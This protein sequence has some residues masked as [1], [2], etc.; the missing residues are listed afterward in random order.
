MIRT[1]HSGEET[2][3]NHR[4]FRRVIFRE[5]YQLVTDRGESLGASVAFDLSVGGIR[6]RTEDFLPVNSR[7]SI[8][9]SCSDNRVVNLNGRVAWVQKVP[10]S[11]IYQAGLE[12]DESEQ[13]L[14]S[15]AMLSDFINGHSEKM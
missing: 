4:R 6:L 1:A 12:F 10:H 2:V 8:R 5:P 11:D 15:R 9:F 7:V 3:Q 14:F 13:D